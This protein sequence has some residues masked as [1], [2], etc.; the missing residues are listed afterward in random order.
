M[1]RRRSQKGKPGTGSE[2]RNCSEIRASPC[3]AAHSVTGRYLRRTTPVLAKR[4]NQVQ[5]PNFATAAKF[6][7]VPV[8]QRIPLLGGICDVLHQCSQKG[9]PGTGS[10]FRNCS[11][12]RASPCFAAH[13][14]TGRY[15]RRTTPVLAKGQTRYRLR[16][17]QLQR[18]SSQSLFCSEFRYWAVFATYYT[19]AR[20]KG[21]PGTGSEFRNCS[22]IRA[23]PCFAAHSVTG[24][25]L[26]RT[27]PVLA[28]GQTPVLRRI[29]LR[30]GIAASWGVKGA[31][32]A[33]PSWPR[34]PEEHPAPRSA[35][36]TADARAQEG[37]VS[38]LPSAS[39]NSWA[40]DP[41]RCHRCRS[42]RH[43]AW[44]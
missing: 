30:G 41:L 25:Y 27:T 5:A 33:A 37:P 3:F 2:F 19:S 16:I 20:K 43:M 1:M 35:A 39:E 12:I 17:S 11:E 7:P 23:S 42:W 10:E 13:S 31:T 15:L 38:N 6:E 36:N 29:P 32:S 44:K 14:V 4:A 40:F 18:N 26:R 28:K 9:K 34:F 21:K 8:L 24:R 22:E